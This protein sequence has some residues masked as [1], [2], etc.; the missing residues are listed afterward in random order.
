MKVL[1]EKNKLLGVRYALLLCVMA[2]VLVL[3]II[4]T[5]FVNLIFLILDFI[6]LGLLI[7]QILQLVNYSKAPM[8]CV[9]IDNDNKIHLYKDIV[10]D[11]KDIDSVTHENIYVPKS[12]ITGIGKVIIKTNDHNYE[13]SYVDNLLDATNELKSIVIKA[14]RKEA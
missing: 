1:V 2:F 10:L 4:S 9:S 11:A 13:Y 6:F 14:K 7:L 3:C 8:I 5:V 12:I